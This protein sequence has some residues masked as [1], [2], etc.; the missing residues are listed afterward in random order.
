M[1]KSF[2]K[3]IKSLQSGQ[4]LM[5]AV[6][7]FTIFALVTVIGVVS[8]IIRQVQMVRDFHSSK[9]SYFTAEAGSED[10][11]YRIKNSLATSFPE[12]LTLAGATATVEVA[13]IGSNEQQITSQGNAN[14]LIRT[15]IKD[16]TVTDCFEFSFAVQVCLG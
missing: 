8:P 14:N 7:S 13:T 3:K 15:V 1:Q 11:F 16:I 6:V 10:A 2:S 9:Q 12:T 5:L 4:V